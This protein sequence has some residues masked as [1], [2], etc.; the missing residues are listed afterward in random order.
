LIEEKTALMT[1]VFFY[2]K[3][4]CCIDWENKKTTLWKEVDTQVL[5]IDYQNDIF[6][7]PTIKV[8]LLDFYGLPEKM[9]MGTGKNIPPYNNSLGD[10]YISF[11]HKVSASGSC[12][13]RSTSGI[14]LECCAQG[15]IPLTFRASLRSLSTIVIIDDF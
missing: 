15:I 3:L 8:G 10:Q 2:F 5:S 11:T 13:S 1:G 12:L 9:I 7:S 6:K 14:S 4:K